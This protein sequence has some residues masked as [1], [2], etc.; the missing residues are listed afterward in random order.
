MGLKA[1]VQPSDRSDDF[2][3]IG[4]GDAG[5]FEWADIY[6]FFA[7]PPAPRDR[8][9]IKK[10]VPEPYSDSIDWDGNILYCSSG[11]FVNLSIATAYE[12]T[13]GEPEPSEFFGMMPTPSQV[14]AF[15]ADTVRFLR[16]AHAIAPIVFALRREDFEAGGTNFDSWHERSAAQIPE[17]VLPLLEG[18]A[19]QGPRTSAGS[20][21]L[22]YALEMTPKKDRKRV[23]A[24]LL[25]WNE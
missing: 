9:K 17:T 22:A 4:A 21:L 10:L 23:P 13:D 5:Y 20:Y 8:A 1:R 25:A 11:Q 6:V 19:G 18:F 3:F 15:E 24:T 12:S 7:A 2:L 16:E 14:E